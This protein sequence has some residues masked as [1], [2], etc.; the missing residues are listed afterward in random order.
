MKRVLSLGVG[1]CWLICSAIAVADGPFSAISFD[2]ARKQAET[3]KK[4]VFI[5]FHASWCMPCKMMDATTFKDAGVVDFLKNRVIALKV[6]VE[7]QAEL[8]A[9]YRVKVF[10]ALVFVKPDGE[11]A[12]VIANY[13]DAPSFLRLAEDA[14]AGN[15]MLSQL[16]QALGKSPGDLALH[17]LLVD[18]LIVRGEYEQ[19]LE[20]GTGVLKRADVDLAGATVVP[21]VVSHIVQLAKM[22]APARTVL[23]KLYESA[24]AAVL[25]Q[26]ANNAQIA[27]FAALHMMDND[28]R[29]ILN[30]YDKLLSANAGREYLQ[31]VTALW[32]PALIVG[33]RDR[34]IAKHMDI[35]EVTNRMIAAPPAKKP[36]ETAPAPSFVDPEPLR[37]QQVVNSVLDYYRVLIVLERHADADALAERLVKVDASAGMY[38]ALAWAA[39]ETGN[40]T[41]V[42]L[43]QA[44]K[45]YE[46]AGEKDIGAI[47]ILARVLHRLG[48][49]NEAV[50]L[51]K[52]ALRWAPSGFE[53]DILERCLADCGS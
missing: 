24:R 38:G 47:D 49:K 10:P 51:V 43:R 39:Y 41:E 23:N 52:D 20:H 40:V 16:R 22:H 26:K 50:K 44:R 32:A 3:E 2:E 53:R 25:D 35:V 7:R 31:R 19:A 30:T 9:K 48:R 13:V 15:D 36:T 29:D 14:L 37:R 12:E 5:N 27:L 33:G 4:L 21:L 45:A 34:D 6:D 1:L 8:A 18:A 46:L 11:I 28:V 17:V 42:N